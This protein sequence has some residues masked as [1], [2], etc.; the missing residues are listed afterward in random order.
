MSGNFKQKVERSSLGTKSVTA[1]RMTAS[2]TTAQQIVARTQAGQAGSVNR[3]PR[4]TSIS[5]EE[6]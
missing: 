6:K 5:R 2:K 4:K 1:A 3:V